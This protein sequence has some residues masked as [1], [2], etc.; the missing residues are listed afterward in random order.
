MRCWSRG[1]R[2]GPELEFI[3]GEALG[4]EARFGAASGDLFLLLGIA[5]LFSTELAVLDA[6]A[7]VTGDLLALTRLGAASATRS[8]TSPCCGA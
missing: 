2:R 4:L 6:V 1:R 8:S 3:R 7:R 5:V